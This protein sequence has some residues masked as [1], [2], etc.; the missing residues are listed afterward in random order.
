MMENSLI[1]LTPALL[2]IIVFLMI[3]LIWKFVSATNSIKAL[4]IK[5]STEIA[6]IKVIT[7]ASIKNLVEKKSIEIA[8]IKAV[9]ESAIKYLEELKIRI[10]SMDSSN[11]KGLE[12]IIDTLNEVTKID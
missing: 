4:F 1:F 2:L 6:E 9:N 3:L 10:D 8:E 12:K 7:E 5:R 11:Q